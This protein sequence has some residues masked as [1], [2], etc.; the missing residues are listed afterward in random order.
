MRN[1][2]HGTKAAL[3]DATGRRY[4]K[5]N[6]TELIIIYNLLNG[7]SIKHVSV[8]KRPCDVTTAISAKR[9]RGI[10]FTM[11]IVETD[12]CSPIRNNNVLRIKVIKAVTQGTHLF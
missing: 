9:P 10:I 2:L 7:R 4:A 11:I 5:K 8:K 1:I 3:P 12:T 6:L